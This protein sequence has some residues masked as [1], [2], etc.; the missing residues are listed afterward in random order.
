MSSHSVRSSTCQ[1]RTKIPSLV[2][3][4]FW[5]VV[6]VLACSIGVTV[7]SVDLF[8]G[9]GPEIRYVHGVKILS[10]SVLL[11]RQSR[12][13][14]FA[15]FRSVSFGRRL[16]EVRVRGTPYSYS[17]PRRSTRVIPTRYTKV[18]QRSFSSVHDYTYN[19]LYVVNPL[20]ISTNQ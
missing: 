7:Y 16:P 10:V 17:F 1:E 18:I 20:K 3:R 5:C 9:F 2:S 6:G 14:D 11:F 19:P 4:C 12:T 13:Q 8:V 15:V